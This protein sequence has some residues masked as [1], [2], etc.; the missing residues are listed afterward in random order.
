MIEK[1]ANLVDGCVFNNGDQVGVLGCLHLIKPG[2][3]H[4]LS[5][6]KCKFT[7]SF[8]IFI[9]TYCKVAPKITKASNV[10]KQKRDF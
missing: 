1:T 9:G 2:R 5:T 10:K 4:C 3:Y 8:R 7:I 6:L